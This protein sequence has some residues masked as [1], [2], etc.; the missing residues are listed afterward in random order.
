MCSIYGDYCIHNKEAGKKSEKHQPLL[1]V[2]TI[3]NSFAASARTDLHI[4]HGFWPASKLHSCFEVPDRENSYCYQSLTLNCF[5]F[6]FFE[7]GSQVHKD[8]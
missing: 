4:S 8:G 2:T 5:C 6:C 3:Y 7:G 1:R